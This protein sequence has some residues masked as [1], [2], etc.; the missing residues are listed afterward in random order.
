M[1]RTI[2]CLFAVKPR[3]EAC[4]HLFEKKMLG[5]YFHIRLKKAQPMISC[6]QKTETKWN[7]KGKPLPFELYNHVFKL[8]KKRT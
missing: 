5:Y 7:H 6:R 3:V 1:V 8:E 4:A 2:G